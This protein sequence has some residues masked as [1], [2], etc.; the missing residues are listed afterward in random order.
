V[1]SSEDMEYSEDCDPYRLFYTCP[2]HQSNQCE[3]FKQC[4]EP[5]QT[6]DKHVDELN[7][8]RSECIRLKERIN[9]IQ[10]ER[11]NE[12]TDWNRERME[13]TSELSTV[14]A[15]LDKIKNQ[16][17]LLNESVLMPPL[18]QLSKEDGEVDD[19]LI[20]RML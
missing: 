2:R 6:G 12:R 10:Q 1:D 17:K 3:L 4:D 16:I 9:D 7:L 5:L 13:L 11:D 18:D 8:I 20:V 14:K 19:A 15:E